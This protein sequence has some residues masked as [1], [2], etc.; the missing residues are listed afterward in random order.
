MS[1]ARASWASRKQ[2]TDVL[3][4]L[5]LYYNYFNLTASYL[6]ASTDVLPLP[7]GS[8]GPDLRRTASRR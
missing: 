6:P 4:T 1:E 2:P 3:Q 7:V 5:I 8:V